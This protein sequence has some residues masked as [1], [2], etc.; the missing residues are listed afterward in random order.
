MT[1]KG[2]ENSNAKHLER[3]LPADDDQGPQQRRAEFG[4]V[5][6]NQADDNDRERQKMQHSV[7]RQIGLVVGNE[8]VK[9]TCGNKARDIEADRQC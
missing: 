2:Q 3:S 9:E 6:R 1:D 4:P 8:K 7:G 5:L